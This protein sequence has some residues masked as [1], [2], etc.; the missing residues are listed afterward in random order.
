MP[1]E[2]LVIG[3]VIPERKG[4][5]HECRRVDL[6]VPAACVIFR[7]E[8]G[9]L[10]A[11]V[12]VEVGELS[13]F[14]VKSIVTEIEQ[15]VL[16]VHAFIHGEAFDLDI[17]AIIKE[18]KNAADGSLEYHHQ[19]HSHD[20]ITS[21]NNQFDFETVWNLCRS[22]DGSHLRRALNDLRM[23]LI[24]IKD[25]PFYCH[26][27]LETVRRGIGSNDSPN[28]D[29][30]QWDHMWR[31]LG[32]SRADKDFFEKLAVDIRH[33]RDV[34]YPGSVWRRTISS[35]WSIVERYLLFLLR[36]R[37]GLAE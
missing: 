25:G 36:N 19:D 17:V 18:A 37:S 6:R 14:S 3:R 16:N 23:A 11:K 31:M 24:Y 7:V 28:N 20:I 30:A 21:R 33:G 5:T 2:H 10:I 26:R 29:S 22:H 27:A 34:T 8:D 4:F 1:D 12:I 15:T 32:G 9:Q 13:N 35:T